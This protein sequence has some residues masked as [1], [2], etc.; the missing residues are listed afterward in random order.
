M[1]NTVNHQTNYNIEGARELLDDLQGLAEM[2]G[3]SL[4][5]LELPAKDLIH[6]VLSFIGIPENQIQSIFA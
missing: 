1:R 5:T 3:K 6:D 4:D 2:Q